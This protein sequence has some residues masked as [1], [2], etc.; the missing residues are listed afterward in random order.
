MIIDSHT[1]Y[2]RAGFNGSFRYLTANDGTFRIGEGRREDV[3]QAIREAGIVGSVEPGVE[4]ESNTA[5]LQLC[6][7]YS[8][9]FFQSPEFIRQ[10]CILSDGRTEKQLCHFQKTQM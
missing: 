7:Q 10:G 2:A 8:G 3:I 9:F 1:H 6:E 5:V 4:L